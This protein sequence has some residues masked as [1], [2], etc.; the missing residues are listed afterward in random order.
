MRV[1]FEAVTLIYLVQQVA[2]WFGRI[3][4]R[5]AAVPTHIVISGL[6]RMECLV[7]PLRLG[8]AATLQSFHAA[9]TG[10]E[11]APLTV[12]VFDR[13]A[14]IRAKYNFKTPD[15]IHVAAAVEAGC[16]EFWTNDHRLAA[17]T[18][19]PIRVV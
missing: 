17:F 10:A 18:G 7:K 6:T 8:D 11:L 12:A 3:Q 1:Y 9:F 13:A 4:A 16:D 2:P 19:I 5:L 15:A 14:D